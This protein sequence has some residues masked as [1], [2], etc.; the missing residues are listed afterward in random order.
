MK[1]LLFVFLFSSLLLSCTKENDDLTEK[2]YQLEGKVE[3]G[4]FVRGS[5]VMIT[6]LNASFNPTG[7]SFN[8]TIQDHE[9]N[10]QLGNFELKSPYVLLTADGYYFNEVDGN[11][12]DGQ[13]SLQSIV[14]ISDKSSVNVNILTHLKK[15]RILWLIKNENLS[16]KNANAKAQQELLKNFALQ[17]YADKDVNTFSIASGTDEAG[18]LILISS[19]LLKDKTEAQFTDQ[20]AGLC[21]DFKSDGTFT[22]ENKAKF[23][24]QSQT[25]DYTSVARNIVEHYTSLGKNVSVQDLAYYVDWNNDGIAGNELGDKNTER[26]LA[27]ETD[28]VEVSC[29]GGEVRIKIN[30][31]IPYTL[32]PMVDIPDAIDEV[33]YFDLPVIV[34]QKA[35][36]GDGYLVLNVDPATALFMEP[37]NISIS[38]YDSKTVATVK[39]FQKLD[40]TKSEMPTNHIKNIHESALTSLRDAAGSNYLIDAFYTRCYDSDA[41]WKAFYTYSVTPSDTKLHNAWTLNYNSLRRINATKGFYRFSDYAVLSL[42]N[43]SAMLYYQMAVIWG[44]VIYVEDY[45]VEGTYLNKQLKEKELFAKFESDLLRLITLSPAQKNNNFVFVS[46]D[47]P[48]ATLARMYMYTHNYAKALPLLKSIIESG[49]Y[50]VSS[51]SSEALSRSSNELIYSLNNDP[52][53]EYGRFINSAEILPVTTFTEILLSAAECELHLGN[54]A[55]A[56][57]YINKVTS[58]RGVAVDS[59]QNLTGIL[60]SVWKSELKGTGTYFAFLKRNGLA[61]SELGIESYKLILPI[62]QREIDLTP[63]LVQNPSY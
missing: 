42:T 57:S 50:S 46:K 29:N 35:I 27:F 7:I 33:S 54:N 11:L 36:S 44:N 20:L 40:M 37:V 30:S 62:P 60:K 15:D 3:K 18:V 24:K 21:E 45:F 58:K 1:R 22:D 8:T 12:S 39:I 25:L 6:E 41:N 9:G 38:S 14:D 53:S 13:I 47:S 23:N 19:A 43:L 63:N 31:N 61:E 51:S 56:L 10:F 52:A 34:L 48:R 59:N 4:P 28:S 17:K 5:K 32:D 26:V 49:Y 55:G 2:T 16:F